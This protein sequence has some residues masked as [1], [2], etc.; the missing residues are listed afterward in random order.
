MPQTHVNGINIHYEEF[1][2]GPDLVV[3]HGLLG[4]IATMP[5]FGDRLEAIAA[6]GVHV[7]AYDARGHGGS[8]FSR[9][10]SDY[11][12]PA[13]A[14]DMRGLMRSLGVE[15]ASI[16]GGSMGA[17]TAITLALDHPD[18]VEKLILNSPP[19][20]GADLKRIQP[21]F[22]GLALLYRLFGARLTGRIVASL[23]RAGADPKFDIGAFLAGQRAE[24]IAAAIHGLF[25]GPRLP[26]YRYAEIMQ[27]ALI[28]THPDDP[29]HPLRAGEL[30]HERLPH[31]KLAVAPT[32]TYWEENPDALA[33]V[34]A[35]FVRG[36]PIAQ[37]LPEHNHAPTAV[38]GDGNSG[39]STSTI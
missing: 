31:A 7:I 22:A 12:W 24:A 5:L 21:M 23:P 16:Y 38:A 32:R 37:G 6:R 25:D 20:T 36:E 15:R 17:G 13:L 28:L 8:G 29:I 34:V 18:A 1:G 33:H 9:R 26:A 19:P 10:A 14:S 39:E 11:T 35:S 27:P 2:E 30:L 4:S 3:A